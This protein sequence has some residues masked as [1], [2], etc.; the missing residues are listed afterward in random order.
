M[1]GMW[2]KIGSQEAKLGSLSKM[3]IRT[4]KGV[5]VVEIQSM[6]K[7]FSALQ[8]SSNVKLVTS[9]DT[10]PAFVTRR[11]KL[12]SSQG[13]QK[14]INYRKGQYMQKKVPYAVIQTITAQVMIPSPCRSKNSAHKLISRRFPSQHT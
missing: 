7:A 6:W 2:I 11:S 4:K 10:L 8:R 5:Q 3:P 14:H 12:H 13:N 1:M 9:L